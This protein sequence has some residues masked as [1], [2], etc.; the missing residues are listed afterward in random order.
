M[1]ALYQGL[2]SYFWGKPDGD[3]VASASP[4]GATRG[5]SGSYPWPQGGGQRSGVKRKVHQGPAGQAAPGTEPTQS[6]VL[7]DP[8]VEG[9]GGVQSLDWFAS[10]QR[11]DDDGCVADTFFVERGGRMERKQVKMKPKSG[12]VEVLMVD[13]AGNVVLTH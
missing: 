4:S 9:A 10:R 12:P 13:G 1:N 5:M 11:V 3:D 8:A 6:T 2:K 7:T